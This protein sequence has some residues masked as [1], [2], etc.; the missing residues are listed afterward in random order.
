[1]SS[2]SSAFK[3]ETISGNGNNNNN[4]NDDNDDD[5]LK[6]KFKMITKKS[7]KERISIFQCENFIIDAP[8]SYSHST[9]QQQ[10]QQQRY[11]SNSE[12]SISTKR[13]NL[14]YK[15]KETIPQPFINFDVTLKPNLSIRGDKLKATRS[16]SPQH[17]TFNLGHCYNYQQQQQQHQQQFS[18][19]ES[20]SKSFYSLPYHVR[21]RTNRCNQETNA[22]LARNNNSVINRSTTTSPFT[23]IETLSVKRRYSLSP[24]IFLK[25]ARTNNFPFPLI[26]LEK[27]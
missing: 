18:A 1:M 4:N 16:K 11:T 9:H 8:T 10:Q 7:K 21:T 14:T 17:H 5:S 25:K 26:K 27:F 12:R 23:F 13:F 15:P 20:S 6:L 24:Q 22:N 19:N 2:S 3:Y